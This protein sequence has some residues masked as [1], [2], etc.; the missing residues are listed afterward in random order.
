MNI[1]WTTKAVSELGRL[2]DFLAPVYR[3]A[4][5]RTVQALASAPNRLLEQPRMGERLEEFDPREVRRLLVGHYEMRYEITPSTIYVLT[6]WHTRES[7]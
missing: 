3:R 6:L 7:R 1:Q 5:A 2:H 4:A